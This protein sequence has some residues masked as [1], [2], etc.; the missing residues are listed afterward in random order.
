MDWPIPACAGST[1]ETTPTPP[2]RGDHPRVRGEHCRS[3]TSASYGAGPSPRARGAPTRS[4]RRVP[5]P[6]TIPA[7]AGSTVRACGERAW[8]GDHPRVRGEHTAQQ[9]TTFSGPGPSPRARGAQPCGGGDQGG[10]GTI[11]ACAGSTPSLRSATMAARDHPRVRGEHGDLLA[12]V[13]DQAGPSPRA[14]G[15]RQAARLQA[16]ANG[17]IPACAGSTPG[18][19]PR[20]RRH[21]D[22]PRVRGEHP[23]H[24]GPGSGAGGPSPRARGARPPPGPARP[25][26]GTIPACAGSTAAENPR[27]FRGL[28]PSPRARGAPWHRRVSQFSPGTIPA[29]AGSTGGR[30]WGPSGGGGPSPRARGAPRPGSRLRR[31]PRDHPRVRGE[32][33]RPAL[34]SFGWGGPSPRAR[35][36]P[37]PGSR[38]RRR[39]RDHPRVRGEH[40]RVYGS[41][42][43]RSGPSPRARGAHHQPGHDHV[44]GGT[45]PACA[46]STPAGSGGGRGLGDHPRVRGEHTTERDFDSRAPGPSPRARG[47]LVGP[48]SHLS[49]DGTIPACAGSTQAVGGPVARYR[50]HPRVRGEHLCPL[51]N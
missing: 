27:L 14:R 44:A 26:P 36:A 12:E 13:R 39:P 3:N 51:L 43:V 50:D 40:V 8:R 16:R 41:P 11:P 17:T 33:R 21:R 29:C 20:H 46:G 9:R 15:A 6:G 42:L 24:E 30:R 19:A 7:C 47:A 48:R 25:G 28:G 23:A 38:L 32:H 37:R 45:I 2:R 1:P 5:S 22:H 31:R 49:A 18:R 35:G 34:G 10:R 4:P